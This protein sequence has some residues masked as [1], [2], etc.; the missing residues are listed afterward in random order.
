MQAR[1]R[2]LFLSLGW[3]FVVIASIGVI[4]PILPTTPFLLLAAFFFA[5]SSEKF[6]RWLLE[7]RWFGS[8]IRNYYE[9]RGML[10]RDKLI[11]MN[12]EWL[13]IGATIH[14]ARLPFWLD[15]LL[16][17]IAVGV[18]VHILWIPVAKPGAPAPKPAAGFL[19]NGRNDLAD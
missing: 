14:F 8:Y 12:L 2:F 19:L 5:R 10:M 13:T 16:F 17:A 1:K 4:L 18:S 6:H 11:T 7:N 3:L 15:L 9:G